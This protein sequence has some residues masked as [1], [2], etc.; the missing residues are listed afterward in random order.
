MTANFL[1]AKSLALVFVGGAGGTLA[2]YGLTVVLPEQSPFPWATLTANIL[3]A[4][5]LGFLLTRLSNN[6]QSATKLDDVPKKALENLRLLLGTGFCGGF[7]S[8]SALALGAWL[9]GIHA[10][11]DSTPHLTFALSYCVGTLLLGA[12][13]SWLG[14][15]LAQSNGK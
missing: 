2:R 9:L 3:G 5:I 12:F 10:T 14:M 8:Y 6:S 7:T 11:T 4:L 15:F 1:S 13:A